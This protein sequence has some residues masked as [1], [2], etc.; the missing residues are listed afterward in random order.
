MSKWNYTLRRPA[1][2]NWLIDCLFTPTQQYSSYILT[3]DHARVYMVLI[4]CRG[5]KVHVVKVLTFSVLLL[6]II[7][8]GALAHLL[9]EQKTFENIQI[10]CN[11]VYPPPHFQGRHT[12]IAFAVCIEMTRGACFPRKQQQKSCKGEWLAGSL[13]QDSRF[14]IF[15]NTIVSTVVQR[16]CR[17]YGSCKFWFWH[18]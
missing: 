8:K 1:W 18:F 10:Y 14:F 17:P 7:K 16:I 4:K 2:Q 12:C 11:Y 3:N 9:K 13:I 6:H 15:L 5:Y